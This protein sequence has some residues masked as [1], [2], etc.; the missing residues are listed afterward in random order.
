MNKKY[1]S[2]ILALVMVLGTFSIVNAAP[3]NNA[4]VNWLVENGLVKGDEWT[5][6]LRLGDTITRAEASAM[7]VRLQGLEALATGFKGTK[8]QFK[9]VKT[10]HWANGYINVV[11][12]NGVVN[13]YED[14]TFRPDGK[15]TYAEIIKMLVVVNG[16]LPV[17]NPLVSWEVPYITK[18]LEVGILKDIN[19]VSYSNSAIRERIFEMV[20]NLMSKEA[21]VGLETYKGIVIENTMVSGLDKDELAIS[22][23]RTAFPN[24]KIVGV[25]CLPLIKQHG[26]LHCV[27]MQLPEG[28][29]NAHLELEK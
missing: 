11:A 3:T 29:I 18:A 13:G 7:V 8:S 20:Y 9:D 1:L 21:E 23:L 25:N 10:S 24:H 4:K 17:S 14:G 27:T 15:I 26:S 5:G 6:E 19:V 22:Q 16:D 28:S 12:S 2:L